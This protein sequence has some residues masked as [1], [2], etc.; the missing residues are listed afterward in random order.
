VDAVRFSGGCV[1]VRTAGA[2]PTPTYDIATTSSAN[3]TRVGR[4]GPGTM[5]GGW[6]VP[7]LLT[8][9]STPSRTAGESLVDAVSNCFVHSLPNAAATRTAA[10]RRH[11]QRAS[12]G[13]RCA[14]SNARPWDPWSVAERCPTPTVRGA[15]RWVVLM[16]WREV[17]AAR[18]E[19]RVWVA[20]LV[21]RVRRVRS[22]SIPADGIV[23]CEEHRSMGGVD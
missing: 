21:V 8:A 3:T 20:W 6:A 19:R 15:R 23:S 1:W 13:A 22:V 16:T 10:P 5:G 7:S 12:R 14:R 4:G 17:G 18:V 9:C 11:L 2:A